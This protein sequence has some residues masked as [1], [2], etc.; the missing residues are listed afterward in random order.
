MI[1]ITKYFIYLSFLNFGGV[2]SFSNPEGLTVVN[3]E[4]ILDEAL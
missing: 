3:P 1:R 2:S 4:P